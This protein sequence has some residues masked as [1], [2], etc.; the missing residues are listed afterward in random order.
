VEVSRLHPVGILDLPKPAEPE[1]SLVPAL[2]VWGLNTLLFIENEFLFS[3]RDRLSFSEF[4]TGYGPVSGLHPVRGDVMDFFARLEFIVNQIFV[5][6]MV[7]SGNDVQKFEQLLDGID[8]FL[9]I[10]L[11]KEWSL[12][13]NPMKEKLN[14][15]KEVRN[16]LPI[17][18]K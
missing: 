2:P 1:P 8:F 16:G 15:L 12:M 13:G 6:H 17:T 7:N 14:C 5:V 9:K 3:Y 18:G 11:L 4:M 10:K